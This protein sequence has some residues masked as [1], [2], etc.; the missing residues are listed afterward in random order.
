M[1]LPFLCRV[2]LDKHFLVISI[3]ESKHHLRVF[4]KFFHISEY[5]LSSSA[6]SF[7]RETAS[8][9]TMQELVSAKLRHEIDL[10]SLWNIM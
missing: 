5:K 4:I 9:S 2:F 8:P 7:R 10:E 1:R 6:Y 3:K